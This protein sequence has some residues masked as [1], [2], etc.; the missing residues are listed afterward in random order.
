[1]TPADGQISCSM[2]GTLVRRVRATLGEDAMRDL[3]RRA[4]VSYTPEFLDDP[5][6]WIWYREA[7]ALLEAA[8]EVTGDHDIGRRVGAEAVRRHAGTAV[9]TLLR[10][11]GSPEAIF[12]HL[13]LAV[14]KFSTVTVMEPLDVAPGSAAALK[15]TRPGFAHNRLM[16]DYVRGMLSQPPVLFGLPPAA[17]EETRCQLR[18]DAECRYEVRW[19]GEQAARAA[20]PQ[21]L[22]T[23]LEA[24]VVAMT[25]RLESVYAVAHDLIAP[26]NLDAALARITERAATAV[27]APRY[28]L[29]V[30]TGVEGS[31]HVHHR[32]FEGHDP[33]AAA[34]ELL[35]DRDEP[36]D[37]SCLIAD[38]ASATRHYGRLMAIST[39]GAFF[40]SER[41]LLEVYAR[42]AASA[43]DTA[44]A[45]E[46]AFQ[47]DRQSHAL[48][49]LTHALATA[50]TAG[51][52][53]RRL[54]A[55]VPAIVDCDRVAIYLWDEHAEQLVCGALS[56]HDEQNA[57]MLEALRVAQA[58]TPLLD[59]LRGGSGPI[60][61][62][63][64]ADPFVGGL[65]ELTGCVGLAMAPIMARGDFHGVMV[66]SVA[67][68]PERLEP[69]PMLGEL[70][71]GT[72]AQA[73]TALANARLMEAMSHQARH[74]NLTG[75]LGHRAFH[76]ALGACLD[77]DG[78]RF[79]LATIDI[80]DFKR[81]NDRYGHPVG[82]EALRLVAEGLRGA[83]RDG[84]AVFRVGGE[85]FAVLIAGLAPDAAL[86]VAERLR[87]AVAA[88]PF[89]EPLRV[90]VG[91]AGWPDDGAGRDALIERA[92]AALYAAKRSGK[93]RTR[94]AFAA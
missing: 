33:D 34:A 54:A 65:A 13:A 25:D 20:D 37:G 23:A 52:A 17:V 41:D 18:G 4:G 26:A 61:M 59:E 79:T 49:E 78:D 85:E 77:G 12:S 16:C 80:D 51:E 75:L 71:T 68:G 11:L 92:D 9:A 44:T 2:A 3:L 43:L 30:R 88:T 15:R 19:D 64:G 84:D 45:L 60:F 42:Y 27:R 50:S 62:V 81:I 5:G 90:S 47:R 56:G 87:E 46:E 35:A 48:L 32:G 57:R 36:G 69:T 73:G 10:S 83:V 89:R 86:P 40:P 93:D 55:S 70:L 29:A 1:M 14:T 24:Q 8:V 28:L 39:A 74:D 66:V 94:L 31:L 63:P 6:N 82:D 53:A 91:L 67:D 72:A 7:V 76:E 58:D 38:V 21:Q 22:I